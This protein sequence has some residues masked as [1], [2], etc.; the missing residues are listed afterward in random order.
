MRGYSFFL[1]ASA[2]RDHTGSS[3]P[4]PPAIGR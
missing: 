3:A 1:A 2:L 4:L